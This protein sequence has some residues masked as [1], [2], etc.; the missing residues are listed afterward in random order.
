MSFTLSIKEF[1]VSN[2]TD[3]KTI[4]SNNAVFKLLPTNVE[5]S[6]LPDY[7]KENGLVTIKNNGWYLISI[8]IRLVD[9]ITNN[10]IAGIKPFV[11]NSTHAYSYLIENDDHIFWVPCDGSQ[12]YRRCATYSKVVQL[13]ENDSIGCY[14]TV[15]GYEAQLNVISLFEG[16]QDLA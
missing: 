16:F 9:N 5:I 8:Y 1:T 11:L 10:I 2:I 6:K 15:D 12:F 7:I 3:G 4:F 13:K 14:S